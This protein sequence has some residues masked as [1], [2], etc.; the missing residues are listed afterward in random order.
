MRLRQGQVAD[1]YPLSVLETLLER[2]QPSIRDNH[3]LIH[4]I[5]DDG[6]DVQLTQSWFNR[7]CR[8]KNWRGQ[9]FYDLDFFVLTFPKVAQLIFEGAYRIRFSFFE[10]FWIFF[11]GII[12]SFSF[13]PSISI[14]KIQLDDIYSLNYMDFSLNKFWICRL[15]F[16]MINDPRM[17]ARSRAIGE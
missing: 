11:H 16:I 10:K 7:Q 14:L 13:N 1:D 15:F 9:I 17:N 3:W 8:V 4:S 6:I 12:H 2:I 5:R